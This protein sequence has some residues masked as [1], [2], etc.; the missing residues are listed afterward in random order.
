MFNGHALVDEGADRSVLAI[1]GFWEACSSEMPWQ[2]MVVAV[3]EAV[4]EAV[5]VVEI[6]EHASTLFL[7]HSPCNIC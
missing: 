2:M 7:T 1:Q 6:E 5:V 4:E 3:A